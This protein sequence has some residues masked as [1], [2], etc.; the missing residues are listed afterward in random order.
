MPQSFLGAFEARNE[1]HYHSPL[2]YNV[3]S[4]RRFL[5]LAS[6]SKCVVGVLCYRRHGKNFHHST[7]AINADLNSLPIDC[8]PF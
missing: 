2:L 8:C 6:H 7:G 5:E 4:Q 3:L 1:D